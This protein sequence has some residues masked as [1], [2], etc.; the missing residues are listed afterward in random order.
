MR[1]F[2]AGADFG[3]CIFLA[4]NE[5]FMDVF[6]MAPP[7]WHVLGPQVGKSRCRLENCHATASVFL[8]YLR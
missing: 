4:A 2:A 8:C 1:L 3:Y 5:R 6:V 7:K